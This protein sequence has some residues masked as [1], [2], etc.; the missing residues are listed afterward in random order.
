MKSI[1]KIKKFIFVLSGVLLMLFS[2]FVS[3]QIP[4]GTWRDHLPYYRGNSVVNT[5]DRIFC[6]SPFALFY[7]NPGDYSVNKLS[8]TNGLSDVGISDMNFDSQT[9]CLFIAYDN[10]NIDL[11][12]GTA[13]YNL[14]DIKNKQIPG[15][16]RI[17]QVVF[18]EKLAFL[19]C[20]FGIVVIDPE[21]RE[22]KETY[23][24]GPDG[25][26]IDVLSI[27]FDEN[28]IYAA[29]GSGIYK[30]LKN[31]PNL[32]DYSQWEKMNN[33]PEPNGRYPQ[34]IYF[35]NEIYTCLHNQS[36]NSSIVYRQNAGN[37]NEFYDPG[38]LINRLRTFNNKLYVIEEKAI[39][40][41]NSLG[42]IEQ[43][44]S[45]YGFSGAEPF[46]ACM[47]TDGTFYIADKAYGLVAGKGFNDFQ[48]Y[49]PNSPYN[50][51]VSHIDAQSNQVVVAGGGHS[52][53]GGSIGNFGELY[54]FGNESWS[55]NVMWTSHARDISTVLINPYNNLQVYAGAWGT[56]VFVFENGQLTANYNEQNSTLQSI[57]PGQ[58]YIRIGG[59]LLDESQNLYVTNV[60][61]S[62]PISVKTANGNWY[63][64]NYPELTG[65]GDVAAIIETQSGN[66]WVQLARN[67]GLFA[68]HDNYTP[69]N[70]N[71]DLRKRFTIYD[72]TGQFATSEVFSIAE[73]HDGVIWVGTDIG[74]FTYYNPHQVFTENSFL[75]SRVK[76]VDK[77]NPEIVQYLLS[78]E[79]ITAIA[80]D[81][82]NRKWFGTESSG[83]YLMSDNCE[84]EIFHFTKENSKLLS[85]TIVSIAIEP[86]SGEVFF[87]TDIGVISYKSTATK[88]DDLYADAY[89]YPNPVRENYTGLITIT[90]LA[91]NVDVKITDIAG[92]IVY[93]TKAFGGQAIW[94][95]SNHAGKRVKTG[96]YLIFCTDDTGQKSKVLKLLFIN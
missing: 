46:D 63:A 72:E 77:N 53:A 81:G 18:Q 83:V 29:T 92:Q 30:A 79:K 36:G 47:H 64:Y 19:A 22:V 49:I 41:L 73:D 80:I 45:N 12:K 55:S 31:N 76:V 48:F 66:K 35:N 95:G 13:I 28:F 17:Y 90:G 87:G 39:T 62:S 78:K 6:S 34:L 60:G 89:V 56:G 69:D 61:V 50:N 32:I 85:N 21:K 43:K 14:S 54:T 7:Y 10:A 94:N 67:G 71:D 58:D 68:F 4:V 42:I 96:V 5:G 51:H 93:Q 75:A 15:D 82:A 52:P 3:A 27:A 59:L 33:L 65:T 37:W 20:G 91:A 25:S 88:G 11:I 86:K 57:F 1:L 2:P 24:I 70:I 44:I 84:E 40:L 23:Y 74:V 8:R 38:Q 26:A 9:N 16:K